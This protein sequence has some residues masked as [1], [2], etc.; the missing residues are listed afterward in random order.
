MISAKRVDAKLM[1]QRIA[2][3]DIFRN[4]EIIESIE[5][6]GQNLQIKKVQF[7]L[8]I[9]LNQDCDLASDWRDREKEQSGEI[10]TNKDCR[11]LHLIVA[12][13]FNYEL[14]KSG[15]QW[16]GVFIQ[17]KNYNSK[18]KDKFEN[19]ELPRY[20]YLKFPESSQDMEMI[21]DFK[22]FFTVST[23]MMYRN[24]GS[25][26]C[27]IDVLYRER[28]CQRFANYL[29]RIGLPDSPHECITDPANRK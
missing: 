24:I 11:L 16:N 7:P 14:F 3:G 1:L 5:D 21:V 22:H 6:D 17:N 26:L 27:S 15:Q 9:C 8:V 28:L 29:S 18:L 23:E 12:P 4:I 10:D 25:R 13:V 2:Q 19:N 20:H